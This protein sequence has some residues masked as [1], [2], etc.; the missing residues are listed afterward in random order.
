MKLEMSA[1]DE[2]EKGWLQNHKVIQLI[3]DR[4]CIKDFLNC[5]RNANLL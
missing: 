1:F 3:I 4:V 5:N 2:Q